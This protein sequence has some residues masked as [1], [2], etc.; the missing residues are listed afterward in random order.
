VAFILG[1]PTIA[2]T[3]RPAGK[4]GLDP[5]EFRVDEHI[6]PGGSRP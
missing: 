6:L 5:E 3:G 2:S 1:F 4:G